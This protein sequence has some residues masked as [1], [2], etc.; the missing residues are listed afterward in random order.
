LIALGETVWCQTFQNDDQIDVVSFSKEY[1]E[2]TI[3]LEL[4]KH[5]NETVLDTGV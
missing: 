2:R 3:V 1:E 5:R 4:L